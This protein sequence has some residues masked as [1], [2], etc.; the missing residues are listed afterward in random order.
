MILYNSKAKYSRGDRND[1]SRIK[2][3][4]EDKFSNRNL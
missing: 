4:T 1:D 2:K 3:I